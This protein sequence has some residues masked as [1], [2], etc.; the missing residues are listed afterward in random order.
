M[1]KVTIIII[2]IITLLVL[3]FALFKTDTA[4]NSFKENL[5]VDKNSDNSNIDKKNRNSKFNSQLKKNQVDIK[6]QK[7]E[8]NT[9]DEDTSVD[10]KANFLIKN[11]H[12]D[13]MECDNKMND[14]FGPE[15]SI[16]ALTH[17][18]EFEVKE[19]LRKFNKVQFNSKSTSQLMKFLSSENQSLS[20]KTLDN[21]ST[22]RPCRMFQ[23]IS[24]LDEL[25]K[26][27]S[28]SDNDDFKEDVKRGLNLYF[29]NEIKG[30]SSVA[31]L[32]MVLN[33]IESFSS[34]SGFLSSDKINTE[35]DSIIDSLEEDYEDVL[36]TAENAMEKNDTY[37]ETQVS[38]ELIKK[39]IELND[40]YKTKILLF[41][42]E[43]L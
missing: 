36:I 5:F 34:E 17:F 1:K 4:K 10:E 31:N 25:R 12:S 13:M 43:N 3:G 30:S 37:D 23:K 6:I 40:K 20:K 41:I 22:I 15:D 21:I 14:T 29:E 35:L 18:T 32:T 24:F 42:K 28:E 39:E 33:M 7:Y 11:I 8:N 38:R 27:L 16:I 19:L 9:F 2:F 26:A